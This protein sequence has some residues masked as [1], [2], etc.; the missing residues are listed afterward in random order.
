MDEHKHQGIIKLCLPISSIWNCHAITDAPFFTKEKTCALFSIL[1]SLFSWLE[2][3]QL[4]SD[5]SLELGCDARGHSR[6]RKDMA[7]WYCVVVAGR[8]GLELSKKRQVSFLAWCNEQWWF[9]H[10]ESAFNHPLLVCQLILLL[11]FETSLD[12]AKSPRPTTKCCWCKYYRECGK[13]S[14]GSK[15]RNSL[16]RWQVDLCLVRWRI[17]EGRLLHKF[18][19]YYQHAVFLSLWCCTCCLVTWLQKVTP[20]FK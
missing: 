12:F 17:T 7:I 3:R 10:P 4:R 9:I 2:L 8:P 5:T 19:F 6:A 18:H 14:R 11:E 1:I 15:C 16:K 13:N 20:F